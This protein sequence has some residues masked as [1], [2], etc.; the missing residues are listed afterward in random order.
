MNSLFFYTFSVT[1]GASGAPSTQTA[2]PETAGEERQD[3]GGGDH[4]GVTEGQVGR[5]L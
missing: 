4:A 3:G 1:A 2:P 5:Q